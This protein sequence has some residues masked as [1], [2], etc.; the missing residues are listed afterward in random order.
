MA[1]FFPAYLSEWQTIINTVWPEI[2]LPGGGS[3]S[4]F[5]TAIQAVKNNIE[6]RM[7]GADP[8]LP[9]AFVALGTFPPANVTSDRNDKNGSITVFYVDSEKN[10][11]TQ[12]TINAKLSALDEYVRTRINST[13]CMM[14]DAV[15]DSSDLNPIM[16][17]LRTTSGVLV[18]GGII[19]FPTVYV[20]K[21]S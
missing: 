4:N 17:T 21:L 9:Y 10:G 6:I 11:A 1:D 5:F 8:A 16:Q 19:T 12:T 14:T 15:I 2:I 13:F 20:A 7:S 3:V 18:C